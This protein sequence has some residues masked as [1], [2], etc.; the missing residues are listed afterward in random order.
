MWMVF[1]TSPQMKTKLESDLREELVEAHAWIRQEKQKQLVHESKSTMDEEAVEGE[2]TQTGA[3]A[4]WTATASKWNRRQSDT[5]PHF[6]LD[7]FY[8]QPWKRCVRLFA[9]IL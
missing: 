4:N 9:H 5:F 8:I 3:S 2:D 7:V 6:S 1:R